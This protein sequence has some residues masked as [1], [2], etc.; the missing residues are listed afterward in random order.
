MPAT[1]NHEP[2]PLISVIMQVHNGTAT[3]DRAIRSVRAQTFSDWELVAVDDVSTD[4]SYS[5]LQRWAASDARIR[6]VRLDENR[7]PASAR[8]AA[9]GIARGRLIAYLDHDDEY[10][11]DYLAQVDRLHGTGEVL[12]FA[13]D[14]VYDDRDPAAPARTWEPARLSRNLFARNIVVPLGVAHRRTLW[15]K[16]GGFNE[17]VWTG[18]D[19]DFL[20]RLARAGVQFA[21]VPFKSGRYHVHADS[22]CRHLRRTPRR[23][24]AVPES[25]FDGVESLLRQHG[26]TFPRQLDW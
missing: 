18:E 17:L 4:E 1:E 5:V 14:V 23:R 7:G 13:L 15:E 9:I 19:D 8:N 25:V 22:H 11:P 3:L 10:Y 21:F 16:V 24:P 20:R 12:I 2:P 26:V 6:V